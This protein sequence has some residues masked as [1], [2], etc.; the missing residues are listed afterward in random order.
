MYQ[1]LAI[2]LPIFAI[3]GIGFAATKSN[4]LDQH[5]VGGIGRFVLYIALPALIIYNVGNSDFRQAFEPIFFIIYSIGTLATYITA[6]IV[7]R[8]LLKEST[9]LAGLKAMGGAFSNSGFVG[10]PLLIQVFAEPP[11]TAFAMILVFENIILMPLALSILE[12]GNRDESSSI[13]ATVTQLFQRL[14]TN[15][16]I[17]SIVIGIGFSLFPVSMPTTIDATLLLLS[18]ASAGAALFFIGASLGQHAANLRFTGIPIVA[19]FKLIIH[20]ALM[21]TLVF[22]FPALNGD[23]AAAAVLFASVPMLSIYPIIGARFGYAAFCSSA[24]TIC[25]LISFFT[26]T[27][28]LLLQSKA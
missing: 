3:I 21:A 6:F 2:I 9:L 16:I 7:C 4:L 10:F 15:P 26:I 8:L 1:V 23:M 11:I 25:T 24:I 5:A 13:S 17:I 14:A 19:G 12:Y 27:F 22:L 20:P 18:N 28:V